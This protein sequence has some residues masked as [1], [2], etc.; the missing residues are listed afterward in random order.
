MQPAQE[1]EVIGSHYDSC[2]GGITWTHPGIAIILKAIA[3]D[4][5]SIL[6]VGC[7]RGLVGA[8]C[9]LYRSPGKLVGVDAHQPYLRFCKE[10][11]LYDAVVRFDFSKPSLPFRNNQFELATCIEVIEHL[12]KE[13]GALLLREMERVAR[14]IVLTTPATFFRRMSTTAIRGRNMCPRGQP[15]TSNDE[16]TTSMES[17]RV[18]FCN[19]CHCCLLQ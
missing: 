11:R 5:D 14:N 19:V 16:G 7:G 6:D 1:R 9:R 17:E 2:T 18:F 13:S 8:L 3:P 15:R 10:H 12:A 4:V